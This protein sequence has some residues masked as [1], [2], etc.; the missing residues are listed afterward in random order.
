MVLICISLTTDDVDN[1]HMMTGHVAF[2]VK[3]VLITLAF[4]LHFFF[5]LYLLVRSLKTFSLFIYIWLCWVFV[6]V[7]ALL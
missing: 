6:A 3:F 2:S 4:S 1:F 7:W 5:L